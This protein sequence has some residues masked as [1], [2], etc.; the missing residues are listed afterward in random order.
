MAVSGVGSVVVVLGLAVK[1]SHLG[2]FAAVIA[3]G[4]VLGI[5]GHIIRSRPLIV[6]G[7]VV[8]GVTSAYYVFLLEP[9]GG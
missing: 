1:S 6:T 7:I 2:L 3:L 9:A 5:F 4:F 8:V